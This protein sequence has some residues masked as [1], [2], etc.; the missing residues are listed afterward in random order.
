MK[1]LK[2]VAWI[3]AAFL[4]MAFLRVGY[5]TFDLNGCFPHRQSVYIYMSGDWLVGENRKCSLTEEVAENGHLSGHV[6]GLFCQS[7]EPLAEPHNIRVTFWGRI[8]PY[9]FD[10]HIVEVRDEWV[11]TRESDG[12]TCRYPEKSD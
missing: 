1:L 8:N 9:D 3:C 10:G 2:T 6:A 12:F 7:G 4:A 5:E 11:C